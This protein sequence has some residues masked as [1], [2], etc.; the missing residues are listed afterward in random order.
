MAAETLTSTQAAANFP[1]PAAP[2]GKG[3]LCVSRGTYS[4]A[5]N[6]EDGDI[7]EMSRVPA[8]LVVEGWFFAADLDTGT[9]SLDMDIGWAANGAESADPDGLGNLGVLS[10][11][12]VTGIKPETGTSMPFG[13][14]LISDGSQE[15]TRETVIQIEANAAANSFSAGHITTLTKYTVA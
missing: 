4:V 6:V 1:G 15:F 14:V 13:G 5:A 3:I 7:F 9:E 2:V 12:A 11:D 8:C 10:G